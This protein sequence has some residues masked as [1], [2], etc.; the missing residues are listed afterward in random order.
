[1]VFSKV[2]YLTSFIDTR[3]STHL[4]HT[5]IIFGRM[6]TLDFMGASSNLQLSNVLMYGLFTILL[7]VLAMLGRKR[8]VKR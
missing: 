3:L 8:Q 6:E 7:F 1:M 5:Q 4:K 2:V